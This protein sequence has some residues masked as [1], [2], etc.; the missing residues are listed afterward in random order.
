MNRFEALSE[1]DCDDLPHP[2]EHIKKEKPKKINNHPKDTMQP[3][4]KQHEAKMDQINNDPLQY[5]SRDIATHIFSLLS[6]SDL[7]N[8]SLVQLFQLL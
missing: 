7:C 1:L 4:G 6:N 2:I 3:N 5:I 8:I